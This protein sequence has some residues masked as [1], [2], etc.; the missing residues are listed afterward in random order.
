MKLP[1]PLSITLSGLLCQSHLALSEDPPLPP[2]YPLKPWEI[3]SFQY[4]S[5]RV[6]P[7]GTNATSL[8]ITISNPSRIPAGPAPHASG[9]G[10]VVFSNST[11]QCSV[12]WKF[13][14]R[15]PYGHTKDTCSAPTSGATTPNWNITI[16]EIQPGYYMDYSFSLAYHLHAY[17][18]DFYKLLSGHIR[19][20]PEEDLEGG[21][22][23][24]DICSY[25]LKNGSAPL[26]IQPVLAE[27][28]Y[29][30]G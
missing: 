6:G 4:R 7:Y 28:R 22:D 18:S 9:G 2:W 26:L 20:Q 17:G 3:S 21:C 8:N 10:Y 12:H 5:P 16:N 30:C 19:L 27:C 11:A 1:N 25:T 29:A 15:T 24:N 13:D 14:D 23:E